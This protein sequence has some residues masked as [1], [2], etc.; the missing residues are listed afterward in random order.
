MQ[1]LKKPSQVLPSSQNQLGLKQGG[2]VASIYRDQFR[3]VSP[4]SR[5]V[6]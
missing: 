5:A 4:K 6:A 1:E 2:A 3:W